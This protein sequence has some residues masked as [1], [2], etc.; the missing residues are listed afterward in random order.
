MMKIT[1]VMYYILDELYRLQTIT[2]HELTIHAACEGNVLGEFD[3]LHSK[4]QRNLLKMWSRNLRFNHK[5][6]T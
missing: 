6:G 2:S 5:Y 1:K 3:K 4:Y